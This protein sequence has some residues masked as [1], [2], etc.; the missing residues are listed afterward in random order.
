MLD[1][2]S[3]WTALGD[4]KRRQI[5]NLLEEKPRTT[6]ELC[7]YFDVSRFAI[8]KH[9]KVLEQ[10]N[11][12]SVKREGRTRWNIL[13]DDLVRFLR[14]T[15]V[16]EDG[17]YDLAEVL[18][19]FPGRWPSRTQESI[20]SEPLYI[21]QNLTLD[22]PPA[23]VF[24][25]WTVGINSWWMPRSS[26]AS[27]IW[28][29]PFVNGRF[30]EA[31]GEEGQGVLFATITYLKQNEELHMRGTPELTGQ[32]DE[33]CLAD[34]TIRIVL[35]PRNNQTQFCLSHHIACVAKEATRV[36]FDTHWRVLLE[37]HFKL[38]LVT[39]VR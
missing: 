18:G 15:L 36:A 4:S 23:R 21:E 8:M 16:G 22:A 37:Q 28:L 34:N 29:E 6:S 20:V 1:D 32:V 14:T 38:F 3:I 33:T 19:L 26:S 13:N 11:L 30:Y 25:A 2:V 5:I 12:I 39:E 10:A 27:Q 24:E 17:P 7:T 31:F 35:E 9:L